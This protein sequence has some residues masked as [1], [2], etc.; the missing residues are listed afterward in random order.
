MMSYDPVSDCAYIGTGI[1]YI[2]IEKTVSLNENVN[3]DYD[4]RGR[5][6]GVEIIGVDDFKKKNEV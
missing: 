5:V 1:P 4:E 2:K 3:I 6:V